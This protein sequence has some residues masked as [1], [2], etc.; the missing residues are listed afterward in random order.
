VSKLNVG[1]DSY[2][3]Q[4]IGGFVAPVLFFL[5]VGCYT[6]INYLGDGFQINTRMPCSHS[7]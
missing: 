7:L 3:F 4:V 5:K 6:Y 1:F 2:N